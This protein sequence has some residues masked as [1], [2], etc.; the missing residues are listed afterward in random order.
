MARPLSPIVPALRCALDARLG[1]GAAP[2][3]RDLAADLHGQGVINAGA[4][5]ELLMVRRTVENMARRGELR[6]AQPVRVP[7]SRRPMTGWVTS[8]CSN[9]GSERSTRPADM[10][11]R[12][13]ERAIGRWS[14]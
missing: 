7:G 11:I 3:W 8:C 10:A 13:L 9:S 4:P 12:S 2:T 1:C 6:A 5:S 14:V